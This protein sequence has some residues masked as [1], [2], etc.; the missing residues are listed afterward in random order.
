MNGLGGPYFPLLEKPCNYHY[1]HL[2]T[3]V[4]C[5]CDYA[6]PYY[7][8]SAVKNQKDLESS[9]YITRRIR[10]SQC[11]DRGKFFL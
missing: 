5:K 10:F 8:F 11:N 1:T 6:F 2:C 4:S 9:D 7:A 3:V